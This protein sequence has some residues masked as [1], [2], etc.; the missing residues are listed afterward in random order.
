MDPVMGI[1]GAIV[2]ARWS[3]SLVRVTGAV[4]LDTTNEHVAD[5]VREC[6]EGPGDVRITDLHVW[7]IGPDAHAA[8]VGV[9]GKPDVDA[10]AIRARLSPVHELEHITI[11]CHPE[12]ST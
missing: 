12:S 2:I 7:R 10:R 5:E 1:V 6:V 4:L 3:W 9:C 11:E 8:I